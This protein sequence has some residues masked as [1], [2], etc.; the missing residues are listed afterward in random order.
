MK[1]TAVSLAIALMLSGCAGL[2]V[3]WHLTASYQT[4]VSTMTQAAH[5]T[6]P[7]NKEADK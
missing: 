3:S 4:N 2:N 1:R 6:N 7:A 5:L